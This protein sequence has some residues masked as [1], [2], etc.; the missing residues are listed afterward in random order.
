L[1]A[2]TASWLAAAAPTLAPASAKVTAGEVAEGGRVWVC[3]WEGM[4]EERNGV[5]LLLR[6]LMFRP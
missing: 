5:G 2:A 4:R 1:G 3:A 6:A